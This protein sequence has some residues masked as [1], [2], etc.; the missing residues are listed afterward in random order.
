MAAGHRPGTGGPQTAIRR[1][2]RGGGQEGPGPSPSR[3]G[4]RS[5]AQ[6][7]HRVAGR[8]QAGRAGPE[9]P[10]RRSRNS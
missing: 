6:Q 5:R 8:G 3:R 2:R 4:G 10:S 1:G 9:Q 7:G